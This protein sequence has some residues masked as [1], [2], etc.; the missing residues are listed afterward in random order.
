[1]N[2]I[3][4][5]LLVLGAV[6]CSGN[7]KELLFEESRAIAGDFDYRPADMKVAPDGSYVVVGEF[8]NEITFEV[9][10]ITE[11]TLTAQS[12][13]AGFVACF[14]A[15]HALRW[16]ALVDADV[17]AEVCTVDL[18][19]DNTCVV[20]GRY[21]GTAVLGRGEANETTL[22]SGTL[23]GLAD[24][25]VFV[26]RYNSNGT[27]AWAASAGGPQNDT[28]RSIATFPD[29]S[30]VIGGEFIDTTMTFARGEANETTITNAA[31]RSM[32]VARF[33]AAGA[34]S[35]ARTVSSDF[36][37]RLGALTVMSDGTVVAVGEFSLEAFFGT[38]GGLTGDED[39]MFLAWY[40][41]NG[42]LKA[43]FATS[44]N[45]D[46]ID[47]RGV[48]ETAPGIIAVAGSFQGEITLG[49][50]NQS[51]LQSADRFDVFLCS[52]NVADGS[53]RWAA[54]AGGDDDDEARDLHVGSNGDLYIVGEFR[55]TLTV[56][57]TVLTSAG[58]DD[59]FAAG[60]SP[61]G[62]P[63][64]AF[65]GGGA[66][67]DQADGVAELGDGS[68]I[69]TGHF[70]GPATIAGMPFPGQAGDDMFIAVYRP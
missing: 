40:E 5:F 10:Q 53:L 49:T 24:S 50:T 23:A 13:G 1:M 68:I 7:G 19:P 46:A 57:G 70:V 58:S 42:E 15:G 16:A 35:W 56:N 27:L 14:T 64:W 2:Q 9:G 52:I 37:S 34:F 31:T 26:A 41:G 45:A 21:R 29:G 8:E 38:G 44:E 11:T 60:Y 66:G 63:L 43:A 47:V 33:D 20:S 17:D 67:N 69:V 25:D 48:A 3:A 28:V 18:L 32:F 4:C 30:C 22:P 51:I 36:V 65:S 62:T 39:D 59:A 54:R 61:N 55:G 6:G 12:Q